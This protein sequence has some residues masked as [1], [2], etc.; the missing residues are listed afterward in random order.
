MMQALIVDD[1]RVMG[2]VLGKILE[3]AGFEVSEAA[4]GQEGLECLR[5][6][7]TPALAL[8]D[9][10]MPVMDGIEFLRTV[11]ADAAYHKLRVVMVTTEAGED[12]RKTAAAVGADA[13]IV[14]PFTAQEVL[15]NIQRLG[16]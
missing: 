11:R 12:Y 7:G 10:N 16:L 14:K 4:N 15:D 1:S 8:V 13:Y 6:L 3:K 5:R 2:S 9:W